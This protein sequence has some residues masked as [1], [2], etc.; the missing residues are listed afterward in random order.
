[1]MTLAVFTQSTSQVTTAAAIALDPMGLQPNGGTTQTVALE[2]D[3]VAINQIPIGSCTD[4][5]TGEPL[6]VDQRGYERPG[7]PGGNCSIGAYEFQSEPSIDCARPKPANLFCLRS[8]SSS[9]RSR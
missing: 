2:S 9:S 5:A 3:S 4:L 8:G 7:K 6:S 1:M